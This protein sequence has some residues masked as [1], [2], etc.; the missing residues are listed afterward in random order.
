MDSFDVIISPKESF[1]LQFLEFF[2]LLCFIL[3]VFQAF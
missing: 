3:C 2:V 1:I